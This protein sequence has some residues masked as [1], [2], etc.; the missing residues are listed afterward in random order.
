MRQ[1]RRSSVP[2]R[3]SYLREDASR[4]APLM[5]RVLIVDDDFDIREP[6]ATLLDSWGVQVTTAT[7]GEEALGILRE[8]AGISAVLLNLA[9]PVLDG[10]QVHAAMRSDPALAAIPTVIL[11][12]GSVAEVDFPGAVAVLRK[13]FSADL[14]QH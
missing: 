11:T 12:A 1:G 5:P 14:L 9:I 10:R 6:L 7:N 2:L 13:P 3:R 4:F 8:R